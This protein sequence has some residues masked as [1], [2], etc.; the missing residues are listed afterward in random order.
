MQTGYPGPRLP[1]WAVDKHSSVHL[2]SLATHK[3]CG[4][5]IHDFSFNRKVSFMFRSLSLAAC[6]I[7]ITSCKAICSEAECW[8]PPMFK[9]GSG[10]RSADDFSNPSS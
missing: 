10:L 1:A 6:E 4:Y 2:F 8:W 3:H 9:R 5:V 7:A